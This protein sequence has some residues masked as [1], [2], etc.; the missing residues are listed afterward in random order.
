M[1]TPTEPNAI[2]L[3]R[4]GVYVPDAADC[5]AIL[6]AYDTIVAER[7]EW[8]DAAKWAEG[9]HQH[10][11][12]VA[13]AATAQRDAAVR[14]HRDSTDQAHR[15]AQLWEA[16]AQEV[17]SLRARLAACERDSERYRVLREKGMVLSPLF[18]MNG[19][20]VEPIRVAYEA[21]DEA[22]DYYR[23]AVAAETQ[24]TP[25]AGGTDA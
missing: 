4:Q 8:R 19:K 11:K 18:D 7:D 24:T 2:A 10:W 13:E 23:A 17:T 20:E 3:L 1:T 22:A 16:S 14:Q 12:S 6:Q 9:Q 21:A 25:H 15:Y 5:D